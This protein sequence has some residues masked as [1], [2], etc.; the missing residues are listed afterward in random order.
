MCGRFQLD[1]SP[2]DILRF[3]KMITA[4]DKR[5]KEFESYFQSPRDI[6][7]SNQAAVLTAE[8]VRTKTWGF[9]LE[10]KLVINARSETIQEKQ[11][12]SN[13]VQE[14]RCII[15]ASVFYEWKD[16]R[17]FV[18]STQ[19]PF[20]FMAGLCRPDSDPGGS[21]FVI[22]TTDANQE[23]QK[24][25]TRMPVIL[26]SFALADYLN[27]SLTTQELAKQLQPWKQGLKIEL[28]L[29]EQLSLLDYI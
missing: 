24:I 11:M 28:A 27:P 20:F 19:E 7:P 18:I 4:V 26:P 29:G 25:H 9:P 12:F 21:R 8:G 3:Y 16:K 1:I 17:K 5:Y 2:K 10:N 6:Y 22:L 13:L 15:P 14:N 23:M